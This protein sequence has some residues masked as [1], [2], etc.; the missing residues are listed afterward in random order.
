MKTNL[1][2]SV[3]RGVFTFVAL[4]FTSVA[5]AQE[6]TTHKLPRL[7]VS[8]T[9][10]IE[11]KF[12]DVHD[13][14]IAY[15]EIGKGKPV[16]YIHG[17]P[18]SS[19]LWRNVMPHMAQTHR[20]IAIDLIGMGNSDKP[21]INYTFAD[22]FRYVSGFID[23]LGAKSV[24][25]V[26]HDWGAALAWEYAH[27]NPDKVNGL[28]F[29]EGVLPPGFPVSS[30]E[31]M[32]EEMGGMFRAFKDPVQGEQMVIENNMFVEKVLPNMINRK[33]GEVAMKSYRAPFISKESRKPV[34]AWP[35]EVP[36]AGEP[37]STVKSLGE[38]ANFMGKTK[39][40]SLLLYADPGVIIPREAISWYI[41][42]I[43]N[44][45]TVFIGQGLHFIQEDQPDAIGLAIADWLR[46]H[47]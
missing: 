20:N 15:L 47:P 14:K 6:V 44:L 22:H 12:I 7:E 37:K 42:K 24:T 41:D 2:T 5:T 18:T 4:S 16:I 25:L 17:N 35:R 11:Q 29:M 36:I 3:L 1:F 30:F 8:E 38:I 43:S 21:D 23:A 28:A 19:Y 31:V 13:S 9:H 46:R 45:E 10:N 27:R 33:L 39:M 32:G 34:L 26:G 40:P